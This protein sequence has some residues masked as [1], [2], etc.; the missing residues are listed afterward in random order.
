M[1]VLRNSF[2]AVRGSFVDKFYFRSY[3]SPKLF[4]D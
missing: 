2:A 4:I 1:T 3:Y